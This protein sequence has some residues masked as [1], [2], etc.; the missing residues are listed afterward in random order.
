MSKACRG[1]KNGFYGKHHTDELKKHYHDLFCGKKMPK[2]VCERMSKSH[3]GLKHSKETVAKSSKIAAKCL[4]IVTDDKGKCLIVPNM[5]QFSKDRNVKASGL[6]RV[7]NQ[8]EK[9]YKGLKVRKI[10]DGSKG[11]KLNVG[12]FLGAFDPITNGHTAL[13]EHLI[14]SEAFSQIWVS[15]CYKHMYGKTMAD[16]KHRL[17]MC[18]T[19]LQGIE[20]VYVFSHEIDIKHEGSTYDLIKL[21]Q[22]EYR[23]CR[24]SV[25]IGLDNANTF[26]KWVNYR[27][28]ERMVQFVVVPRAGEVRDPKVT[29]YTKPPHALVNV[30]PGI[31]P[32]LSSTTVRKNLETMYHR[33]SN[34]VAAYRDLK[35]QLHP[36]VL[37]YI[38][39][40]DLY[41]D[42]KGKTR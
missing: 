19:A 33:D 3:I 8:P 28:L 25:V 22:D 41:K 5:T 29:W 20:N 37:T 16:P 26:D 9:S 10:F 31:I 27:D 30:E 13:I 6:L 11:D 12:L 14:K 7:S 36:A 18:A 40:R 21:L 15:P 1:E 38:N 39:N 34:G 32:E 17:A 23:Y 2:E 4:Y 24:F 35:K 42:T